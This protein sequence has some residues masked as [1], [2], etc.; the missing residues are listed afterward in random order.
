MGAVTQQCDAGSGKGAVCR[1]THT[2]TF[3]STTPQR[4]SFQVNAMARLSPTGCV[5]QGGQ[6]LWHKNSSL[7]HRPE[8]DEHQAGYL[9]NGPM[10]RGTGAAHF[11]QC[12]LLTGRTVHCALCTPRILHTAPHT[13]HSTRCAHSALRTQHTSH[14]VH[15]RPRALHTAHCAHC[16]MRTTIVSCGVLTASCALCRVPFATSPVRIRTSAIM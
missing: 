12:T 4:D 5:P 2:T 8:D 7:H 13:E 9:N 16:K 1:I 11:A 14:V 6:F 3:G 15:C 10:G